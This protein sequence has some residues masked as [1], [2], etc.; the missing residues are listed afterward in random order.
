[1]P[2][3]RDGLNVA[4]VGQ[5]REARPATP[6]PEASLTPTQQALDERLRAWRTSEADRLGLPQF[7]VLGS[8][9]LRNIVLARPQTL[10]E[11]RSIDG[12]TLD[13]AERFGPSIIEL[14]NT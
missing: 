12:L 14:C 4:K 9:T 2:H 6:A 3:L 5:S 11:L 7:F 10:S 8:G 13:K 1:V